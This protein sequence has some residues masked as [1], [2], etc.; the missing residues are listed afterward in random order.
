[1]S[2]FQDIIDIFRGKKVIKIK[3]ENNPIYEWEKR[4]KTQ[5]KHLR[6]K[7]KKG[8]KIRVCFSVVFDSV[9]PA[10]NVYKKML[11]DE[12]FEPFIL[13]IPD[14]TRGEENMFYQMDKTYKTLSAKYS[15]VYNSYDYKKN[16]FTDWSD[17]MDMCFFAN[18]YDT[19]THELYSVQYLRKNVFTMYI[20]YSY[21]GHLKYN[22]N[23]YKSPIY[24][25][26]N[27][28]YVENKK[29]YNLIKKCQ[30]KHIHNLEI[31][32]YPKM[33]SI[34][35]IPKI[36]TERPLIVIAPHHTVR[37]VE[38]Y[39]NISNFLRLADFFLEL[40]QKYPQIDFVFRPHPLLFVTLSAEDIWGKEKVSDYIE[41]LKLNPNLTYQEGGEYFE[42]FVKSSALINDCGSFLLEYFYFG[43]PQCFV[44][45][46]DEEIE[47]EFTRDGKKVLE[48]VYKA[49][50][51]Q[52]ISSFIDNVVLDKKDF[53][54]EKRLKFGR[55]NIMINYPKSTEIIINKIKKE[56]L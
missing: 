55:E 43:K 3:T 28:I 56:L 47:R 51:E 4:T 15:N 19:M 27:K 49:F 25:L 26:F 31:V 53:M 29:T 30:S 2:L 10:E 54:L 42:T 20:P 5:I 35:S 36:Q 1:M 34:V 37:K 33:D 18:P 24:S 12:I 44:L 38:G 11:D 39:L 45:E 17:K 22:L 14:V 40:P 9:F 21:T 32:G 6:K 52:D 48:Y 7:I 23:I 46:N 13:I 50:N 41:R 8:E 16:E